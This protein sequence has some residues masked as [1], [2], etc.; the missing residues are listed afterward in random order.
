MNQTGDSLALGLRSVV[1]LWLLTV[2]SAAQAASPEHPARPEILRAYVE[3]GDYA[4]AIESVADAASVWL[5]RP[6]RDR[7]PRE[8]AIF[9][10]DETLLSNLPIFQRAGFEMAAVEWE[11]WEQTGTAPMIRPV[12]RLVALA[13]AQGIEIVFLTG[14]R[15]SRRDATLHN[16]RHA[17]LPQRFEV[18]MKPTDHVGSTGSFKATA[19]NT[20]TRSGATIVLNIGDQRSDLDGQGAP[21]EFLLPN[22]FY[23]TP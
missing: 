19:R 18:I 22:P 17:D 4:R 23:L 11:T 14:R 1:A 16:L 7:A 20:L 15:E 10:L 3:S 5:Q 12:A 2:F 8:I 9:D 21:H 6:D 13:R